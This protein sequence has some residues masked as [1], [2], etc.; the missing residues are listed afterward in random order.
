VGWVPEAP[1][2]ETSIGNSWGGERTPI[3]ENGTTHAESRQCTCIA[4]PHEVGPP[5][6]P[7]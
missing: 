4:P 5:L 6:C 3:S 1:G 7:C 2:V